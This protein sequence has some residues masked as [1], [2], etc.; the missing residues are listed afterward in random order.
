MS[1]LKWATPWHRI[2]VYHAA[3][4][5]PQPT[6]Q[7][8][9]RRARLKAVRHADC[10]PIGQAARQVMLLE[11]LKALPGDGGWSRNTPIGRHRLAGTM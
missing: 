9:K 1:R 5:H 3:A 8:S 2:H 11:I 4:C 10:H 7:S 6:P